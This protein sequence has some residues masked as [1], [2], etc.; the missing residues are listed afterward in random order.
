M[1]T[2]LTYKHPDL[3]GLLAFDCVARHRN[4]AKAAV[5]M[6]V[7]P[8]AM[9][10]AIRKL[11]TR[12]GVRLLNRTTRSVGLT[13]EG[14]KLFALLGPALEQVKS[15][16]L[17]VGDSA[18]SPKG[19]LRVNTSYVAYVT[20]IQPHLPAFSRMFPEITLDVTIDNGLTDIVASRFD[21][22]FRLGHIVEHDMIGIP[23]GPPQ[24]LVVVGTRAYL[25]VRGVPKK[26]VDL[27]G[28]NCIQHLIGEPP[29]LFKWRFAREGDPYSVD[30]DGQYVYND[31]RCALDAAKAGLGLAFVFRQFAAPELHRGELVA[32]LEDHCIDTGRFYLYYANRDQMPSKMRAFIDFIRQG[33]EPVPSATSPARSRA[34]RTRAARR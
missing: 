24:Q 6:E 9:S 23:I 21:V 34:T 15:S 8:T 16:I 26:P 31:M 28:H 11:E 32:I 5:E 30:V 25:K 29:R 13:D 17:Q 10:K 3:S 14:A 12:L 19:V 1:S 2:A 33:N 7:S 20:L 22:G 27:A 18:A 4:F